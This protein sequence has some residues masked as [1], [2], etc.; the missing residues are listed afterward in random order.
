MSATAIKDYICIIDNQFTKASNS[1]INLCNG[2]FSLLHN[3]R[4]KK[5]RQASSF[6]SF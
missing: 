6:T 2:K 5:R 3:N 1:Q 4:F